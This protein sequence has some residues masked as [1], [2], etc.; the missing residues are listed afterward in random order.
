MK[1][2]LRLM[3]VLS[4]F[5][6][7][8][9]AQEFEVVPDTVGIGLQKNFD[10]ADHVSSD[11]PLCV[12]YHLGNPWAANVSGWLR[13]EGNLSEFFIGNEPETVFVPSGTFRY[14][15]SCCLLPI[16]ACFEFPYVLETQKISGRVFS[17]FKTGEVSSSSGT[18]SKTGS[19]VAYTLSVNLKPAPYL[20]LKAGQKKCFDFY[21]IGEQ[22]F[23]APFLVFSDRTVEK[24]IEGYTATFLYKNNLIV[25]VIALVLLCGVLIY[26]NK[27]SLKAL[28]KK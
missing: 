10:I 21:E 20:E 9:N 5:T 26:L 6:T 22:C 4:L 3:V 7:L 23:R 13:V 27:E 15:S 28:I 25:L 14:S 17:D 12:T 2:T 16:D 11:S 24:T 8:V 19:S 1:N 18:G